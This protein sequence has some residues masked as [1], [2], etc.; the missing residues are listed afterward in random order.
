MITILPESD[1]A[2]MCIKL[3][4]KLTDAEY[5]NLIPQV[6][7]IIEEFGKIKFYINM[8]DFDGWEW[9]VAWDDFAFGIKH[10]NSFEKLAIVGDTR[11]VELAALVGAKI[12]KADVKFFGSSQE[13]EALTWVVD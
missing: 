9:R 4:G 13:S 11:W 6:E 5:K 12:T 7:S 8:L 3:S 10:W 1:G 2:L